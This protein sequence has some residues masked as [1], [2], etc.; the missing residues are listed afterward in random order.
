MDHTFH[1]LTVELRDPAQSIATPHTPVQFVVTM[2]TAARN[3]HGHLQVDYGDST[4]VHNYTIVGEK[5]S[6]PGEDDTGADYAKLVASYG[7][8]SV[9][10]CA[11]G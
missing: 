4:G 5:G 7:D 11:A 1:N 10:S 2:V 3:R 8:G 9:H 6:I